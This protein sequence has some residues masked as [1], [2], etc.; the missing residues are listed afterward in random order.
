MYGTVNYDGSRTK[1]KSFDASRITSTERLAAD[2]LTQLPAELIIGSRANFDNWCLN[3]TC[4]INFSVSYFIT[5][6]CNIH[7]MGNLHISATFWESGV[8]RTHRVSNDLLDVS[9][10]AIFEATSLLSQFMHSFGKKVLPN[11]TSDHQC[12]CGNV[13]QWDKYL[14][15]WQWEKATPVKVL[16]KCSDIQDGWNHHSAGPGNTKVTFLLNNHF[17]VLSCIVTSPANQRF[18][19]KNTIFVSLREMLNITGCRL[20]CE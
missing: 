16:L 6:F 19:K 8:D 4:C 11:I 1:S 12:T 20:P 10:Y 14:I 18:E 2:C 17:Y 3:F 13:K 5:L 7:R 9:I 15:Q